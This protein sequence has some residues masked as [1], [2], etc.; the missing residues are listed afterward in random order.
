VIITVFIYNYLYISFLMLQRFSLITK[1]IDTYNSSR[2][3]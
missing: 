1:S 3:R 2:S